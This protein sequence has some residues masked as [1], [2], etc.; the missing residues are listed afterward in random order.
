M[1][2]ARYD[3]ISKIGRVDSPVMVLHGDRDDTVPYW[4]AEKLYAA[5]NDPKTLY[6]IRGASHNDTVYVGGEEY[7]RA[8]GDFISP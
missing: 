1:F 6:P 4:M 8:L 5:A 3:S 7:L 2:E